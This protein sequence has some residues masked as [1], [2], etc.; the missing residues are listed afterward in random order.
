MLK[1]KELKPFQ[2]QDDKQFPSPLQHQFNILSCEFIVLRF[3]KKHYKKNK[4]KSTSLRPD[5]F[6]FIIAKSKILHLRFHIKREMFLAF[7]L[8]HLDYF[9]HLRTN[10]DGSSSKNQERVYVSE[11]GLYSVKVEWLARRRWHMATKITTSY[12]N[13]CN[14]LAWKVTIEIALI[15]FLCHNCFSYRKSPQNV[16]VAKQEN[17]ARHFTALSFVFSCIKTTARLHSKST[18]SYN[19]HTTAL[20]VLRVRLNKEP[21][22]TEKKGEKDC[23]KSFKC[24]FERIKKN[25]FVAYLLK[26]V[27]SPTRLVGTADPSPAPQ[28]IVL[29]ENKTKGQIIGKNWRAKAL[30]LH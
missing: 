7:I 14:E 21:V 16:F 17:N 24:L 11:D 4:R 29:L 3:T 12:D 10:T 19:Q 26:A 25:I 27:G 6:L 20:L 28:E 22:V 23:E 15:I 18:C 5:F 1:I 13:D 9:R 8:P 2:P 30:L